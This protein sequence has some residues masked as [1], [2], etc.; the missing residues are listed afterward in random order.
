MIREASLCL[1]RD[2]RH[3]TCILSLSTAEGE[4]NPSG[5]RLS[6][7]CLLSLRRCGE[8][9]SSSSNLAA[10]IPDGVQICPGNE[11]KSVLI[12]L[13]VPVVA[14]PDSLFRALKA[15]QAAQDP[16]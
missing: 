8:A 10:D 5:Q 9:G 4:Q 6:Y 1:A 16:A 15:F 12:M 3:I 13:P 2:R 7:T 11:Q 14:L